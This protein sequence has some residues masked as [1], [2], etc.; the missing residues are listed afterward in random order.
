MV[1]D[2]TW[3]GRP[4]SRCTSLGLLIHSHHHG[5]RRAWPHLEVRC[6]LRALERGEHVRGR[7]SCTNTALTG[8][9]SRAALTL[10]RETAN[11][12]LGFLHPYASRSCSH[13]PL[14][15]S[16]SSTKYSTHTHT[17]HRVRGR[18]CCAP[19]QKLPACTR[20]HHHV[21][22]F[23]RFVVRHAV[24]CN[25]RCVDPIVHLA[26]RLATNE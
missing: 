5:V 9:P 23:S 19:S 21:R 20:H 16:L 4:R 2:S 22:S 15:L 13:E 25:A 26:R 17:H 7:Y 14:P 10:S 6:G 3:R 11:R 24:Q 1:R 18:K 8:I 12:G